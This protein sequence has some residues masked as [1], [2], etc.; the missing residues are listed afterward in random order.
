MREIREND[1]KTRPML[2]QEL[3]GDEVLSGNLISCCQKL[4]ASLLVVDSRAYLG[5]LTHIRS[6]RINLSF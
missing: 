1:L 5:L 2:S 6:I 3:F 4:N